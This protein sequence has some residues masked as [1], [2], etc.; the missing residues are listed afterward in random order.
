[1]K[2]LKK[3][4]LAIGGLA[5]FGS[6]FSIGFVVKQAQQAAETKA[7]TSKHE[8][9]K[10]QLSSSYWGK[11]TA[12]YTAYIWG[13]TN[14]AT[15]PG[16]DLGSGSGTDI[17]SGDIP[18][19][20]AGYTHIIIA[21]FKEAAHS[22]EWNRWNY[23][24]SNAMGSS[25]QYNYFVNTAWDSCNSEAWDYTLTKY[26]VVDGVQNQTALGTDKI[27]KESF[28]PSDPA[29]IDGHDFRGWYRDSALITPY[30]AGTNSG[31]FSLYA[32]FTR[33]CATYASFFLA[34]TDSQCAAK[35][36]TE[37]KWTSLKNAYLDMSSTEQGYLTTAVIPVG[38]T[39][40][41][42]AA[43]IEKCAARYKEI[44]KSYSFNNFANRTDVSGAAIVKNTVVDDSGMTYLLGAL[45][46]LSAAAAGGY[47]FTRKRKHI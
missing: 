3:V 14:G 31:D 41:N 10:L 35:S 6:A 8:K 26:S 34:E 12:Y 19:A 36:V 30:V 15:W 7:E 22:T 39:A 16:I 42:A 40:Y 38:E 45:V 23:F 44:V 47:F 28:T 2:T 21:R 1:M 29:A 5:L 11:E 20:Y 24:D 43:D 33:T 32:R 27:T 18:A 13:G 17:L 9:I 37:A 4:F 25:E 46:V